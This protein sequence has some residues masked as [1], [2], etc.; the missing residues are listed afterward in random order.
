MKF[1]VTALVTALSLATK[2][3]AVPTTV[4][5]SLQKRDAASAISTISGAVDQ[6]RSDVEADLQAITTAVTGDPSPSIVPTV[7]YNLVKIFIAYNQAVATIVPQ[8][9]SAQVNVTVA[10]AQSLLANAKSFNSLL[11]DIKTNFD[12]IVATVQG[13]TL[14]ALKPKLQAA[15]S[16]ASVLATNY[17]NFISDA[18][19]AVYG[20]TGVFAQLTSTAQNIQNIATGLLSQEY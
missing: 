1:S 13:D 7:Q 5:T 3:F 19:N 10:Q 8:V 6:L 9:I 20:P 15:S 4:S 11:T 17:A 12:N 2:I 18:T 14:A 16:V